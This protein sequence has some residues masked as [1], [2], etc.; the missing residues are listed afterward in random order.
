MV[1]CRYTDQKFV[2]SKLS[3]VVIKRIVM[4][5][6]LYAILKHLWFLEDFAIRPLRSLV[7]GY[8]TSRWI[9]DIKGLCCN[10]NLI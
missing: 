9:V 7:L 4:V 6:Y 3:N 8:I 5:W 2:Q 10:F 1:L